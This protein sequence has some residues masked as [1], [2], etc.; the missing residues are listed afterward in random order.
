MSVDL[1]WASEN[2]KNDINKSNKRKM[3]SET[4][5]SKKSKKE[6]TAEESDSDNELENNI[7]GS[8]HNIYSEDNDI[9]FAA[10]IT[11]STIIKLK[12]EVTTVVN[13]IINNANDLRKQNYQ[14]TYP[15]VVVHIWSNGGSIFAAFNFIDF[16]TQMKLKY[17][18]LKF[19]SVIEGNAASAATLISVVFDKRYITEYGYMLIHELSSITW[20][21]YS[22]I[23]DDM[24]NLDKLMERIKNIYGMYCDIPDKELDNILSHDKWWDA[25][26]CVKYELVDKI[27]KLED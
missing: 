11:Q 20:G 26:T 3:I 9:Y 24:E 25:E 14:V 8:Q 15:P 7:C 22:A 27:I 21:K 10:G 16:L 5:T 18:G 12:K 13:K 4:T 1:L 17:G 2:T 19:H 23:K 6:K